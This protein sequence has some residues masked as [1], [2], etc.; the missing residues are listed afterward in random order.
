MFFTIPWKT[1]FP[2]KDR[3]NRVVKIARGEAP[4]VL[5]IPA[6]FSR[7]PILKLAKYSLNI[8]VLSEFKA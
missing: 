6:L 4:F 5:V 3:L 7:V 2:E 8:P 1:F